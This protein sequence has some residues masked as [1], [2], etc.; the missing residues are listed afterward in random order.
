MVL[1]MFKASFDV[2]KNLFAL[3]HFNSFFIGILII[4]SPMIIY[5]FFNLIYW[6]FA[7]KKLSKSVVCLSKRRKI[8]QITGCIILFICSWTIIQIDSTCCDCIWTSYFES[9]S[10]I[11]YVWYYFLTPF[12]FTALQIGTIILL[13]Y[14]VIN[15]LSILPKIKFSKNKNKAISV[16]CDEV[17]NIVIPETRKFLNKYKKLGSTKDI[18]L[19]HEK[20][21]KDIIKK[22]TS[23]FINNKEIVDYYFKLYT[24]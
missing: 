6:F 4:L 12:I 23:V 10:L 3:T 8:K 9:K 16:T 19:A 1:D 13:N 2:L 15:T 7:E 14:V 24:K 20:E 21:Y 22:A 18:I 17:R 5:L 11:Y